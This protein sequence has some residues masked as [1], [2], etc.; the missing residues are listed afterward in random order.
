MKKFWPTEKHIPLL[1]LNFVSPLKFHFL[2][3]FDPR[4]KR[5]RNKYG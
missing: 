3:Y 5:I 2:N 4:L 1:N